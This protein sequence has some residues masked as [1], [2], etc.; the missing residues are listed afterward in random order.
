MAW[1]SISPIG[2]KSV[3][4]NRTTMAANTIYIE[5]T[6]GNVAQLSA[7]ATTPDHFWNISATL[8][9]HHRFIR[10]PKFETALNTPGDPAVGTGMSSVLYTRLVN[11]AVGKVEYFYKN[12]NAVVDDYPGKYQV[13][14]TYRSGTLVIDGP[15]SNISGVLP[16]NVYG[17]VF[18]YVDGNTGDNDVTK[19]IF[20]TNAASMAVI[21]LGTSNNSADAT[22]T[23]NFGSSALQMRVGV[24][25]SATGKTWTYHITYRA[26]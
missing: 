18:L 17:E 26:K 19:A 24:G 11:T 5:T 25:T 15:F 4:D 20:H 9:G 13:T 12:A 10:S 1:T 7:N 2:S 16:A 8:D 3:K 22:S 21:C 6:M 23:L 14:P